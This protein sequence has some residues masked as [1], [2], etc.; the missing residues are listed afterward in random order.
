MKKILFCLIL[1]PSLLICLTSCSGESSTPNVDDP[2]QKACNTINEL[3]SL[4]YNEIWIDVYTQ[5]DN[6]TLN[7]KFTVKDKVINYSIEKLSQ[8]PTDGN[9]DS[10]SPEYI[11]KVSGTANI[12]N[13]KVV[14]VNNET[15]ELPQYSELSGRFNFAK[16]NL[17]NVK[18]NDGSFSATV[19]NS[20]LFY[21]S[22]VNVKNMSVFVNYNSSTINEIRISYNTEN[23]HVTLNYYFHK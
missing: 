12:E 16:N 19:K 5:N 2:V 4:K 11:T 10:A 22:N 3:L 15:V 17:E 6:V 20:T 8:L 14:F 1:L 18:I 9:I 23:S 21:G 7:S 13:G